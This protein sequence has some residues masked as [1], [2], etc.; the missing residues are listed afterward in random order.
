MP[1]TVASPEK[2]CEELAGD[3]PF[4]QALINVFQRYIS[5][6][7]PYPRNLTNGGR[8]LE[9][10]TETGYTLRLHYKDEYNPFESTELLLYEDVSPKDSFDERLVQCLL[11]NS[12]EIS[13]R[14]SATGHGFIIMDRTRVALERTP[15]LLPEPY[16]QRSHD[17]GRFVYAVRDDVKE[18]LT[19]LRESEEAD[20]RVEEMFQRWLKGLVPFRD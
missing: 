17:F 16:S 5:D 12:V 14:Y 7:K 13:F 6:P 3:V 2:F 19:A 15:V 8:G 18:K 20:K 9:G 10:Q 1:R 4:T 11:S